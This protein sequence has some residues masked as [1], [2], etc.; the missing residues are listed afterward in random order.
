MAPGGCYD[1]AVIDNKA[2]GFY[3]HFLMPQQKKGQFVVFGKSE[4]VYQVKNFK[5]LLMVLRPRLWT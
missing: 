5:N 3:N 4:Q 2:K 1:D